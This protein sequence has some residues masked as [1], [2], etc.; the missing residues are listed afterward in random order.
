MGV[1]ASRETLLLPSCI[2][3]SREDAKGAKRGGVGAPT[4]QYLYHRPFSSYSPC[5]MRVPSVWLRKKLT[6]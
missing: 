1:K 4:S 2:E 6:L 5:C 3:N